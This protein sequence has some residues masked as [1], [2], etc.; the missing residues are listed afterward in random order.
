MD[1]LFLAAGLLL[2]A[3][4]A[5]WYHRRS[6]KRLRLQVDGSLED[7]RRSEQRYRLLFERNLVGVVRARLDGRI[8]ECNDAF[9][10]LF[11]YSTSSECRERHRLTLG[12]SP[13]EHELFLERL[14]NE[15]MVG[16]YETHEKTRD[17]ADV[18]LLWN[19]NLTED[20][21]GT[22]LEVVVEGTV[23]DLSERRMLEERVRQGHKLESLGVLAGG[24]AHDFNN[25]LVGI[26][27][28][29]ELARMALPPDSPL[30]ENLDEIE[31]AAN[32]AKVLSQKMLAYSGKGRFITQAVDISRA[33]EE[34]QPLVAGTISKRISIDYRL[35]KCLPE[36]QADTNQLSQVIVNL[37]TNAAEAFGENAGNVIV[38]TGISTFERAALDRAYFVDEELSAGE[39]IYV[40]VRDGGSGMDSDTIERIFD[41]FFTT[42]FPGRGL[43]LPVVL[44]IV[45]GHHGA[46]IV[47]SD[48]GR[49]TL[50][51]V[52]FPVSDEQDSTAPIELPKAEAWR[53]SGRVLLVDD[54]EI[55]RK[56]GSQMI[57]FLGFDVMTAND[58][59]D[60]VEIFERQSDV[61]DLVLLDLTMPR[62]S[63]EEALRH[64]RRIK[65]DVRVLIV[66]GYDEQETLRRFEG[67]PFSGFLQKPYQLAA[68]QEK[69]RAALENPPS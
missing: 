28:N 67:Q 3:G 2:G 53:G 65:P 60:G 20:G 43:G 31:A 26:L 4:G 61:I 22:G 48:P 42:R 19:A 7:L 57:E 18:S 29:A 8:L 5:Y 69:I 6:R 36:I 41:P 13:D 39:H 1:F 66:S 12:P 51:R 59:L 49:G 35:E 9:A 37:V 50:V 27:G 63:G 32:R 54:E 62:M 33:I 46:I 52:L 34:L 17:G 21:S 40:E 56:I 58:G 68:L 11:G 15:G 14:H 16:S 55:V 24:I 64:L 44:G 25:L 23:I 38:E 45:R 30:A 10:R 47:D